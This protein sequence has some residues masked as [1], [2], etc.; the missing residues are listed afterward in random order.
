RHLA[1]LAGEKGLEVLTETFASAVFFF[2]DGTAAEIEKKGSPAAALPD[3]LS[4]YQAALKKQNNSWKSNLQLRLLADALEGNPTSSAFL[5][6]FTGKKY[7]SALLALDTKGLE[8]LFPGVGNENSAL[9]VLEDSG[10]G[11]WYC[12]KAKSGEAGTGSRARA[13]HYEINTTIRKNTEI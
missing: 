8:W 12:S 7:P 9:A 5:A 10:P 11:L 3:A 2:S 13:L 6:L 1:L 4:I